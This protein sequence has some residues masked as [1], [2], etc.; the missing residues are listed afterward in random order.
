MKS[1][2]SISLT[3]TPPFEMCMCLSLCIYNYVHTYT[4]SEQGVMVSKMCVMCSA[5]IPTLF[6][7]ITSLHSFTFL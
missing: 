1:G 6:N 3:T 4:S 5:S 7:T 2:L